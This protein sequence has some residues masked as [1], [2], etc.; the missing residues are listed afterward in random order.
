M[1][2]IN[3]ILLLF[4]LSCIPARGE[5]VV[6]LDT[7]EVTPWAGNARQAAWTKQMKRSLRPVLRSIQQMYQQSNDT[8][9]GYI[10]A[11]MVIDSTSAIKTVQIFHSDVTDT[12]LVHRF[13]SVLGGTK[14]PHGIAS[15]DAFIK[16]RLFINADLNRGP[17]LTSAAITGLAVFVIAAMWVMLSHKSK[18]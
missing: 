3:F 7:V 5:K 15:A 8:S 6:D 4:F 12:A 9:T 16:I 11:Q 17:V 1:R 13:I 2:Q 10:V 18:Y 14:V